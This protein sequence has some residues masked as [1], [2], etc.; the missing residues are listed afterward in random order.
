MYAELPAETAADLAAVAAFL[1]MAEELGISALLDRGVPFT[2]DEA[3]RA[4]TVPESAMVSFLAAMEASGLITRVA[5]DMTFV[6]CADFAE[7]RHESGY[8]AWALNANRPYLENAPEFLRDY[9]SSASKYSRDARWVAVSSQW[10]GTQGFYPQV[11]AEISRGHPGR[12]VD[13]GAGAGRLL[14]DILQ[15][16]TC[17]TGVAIDLSSAACAEARQAA[18]RADVADR[19][20]VMN[21]SIQSLVD[22]PAVLAGADVIHACFVMHDVIGDAHV[23]DAVLST[24]RASLA[25]G[26]KLVIVDAVPYSAEGRERA[27]SAL[28]TYLHQHSMGVDLPAQDSWEVAFR[29]AGFTEIA[30]TPLRMPAARMFVASG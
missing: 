13:L 11:V 9:E 17:A 27:F 6:T 28:F 15:H 24:C 19:L 10:V 5:N 16:L 30:C 23:F 1:E 7:R 3:A 22:D 2:A 4:T 8:L 29:R 25:E 20:Q 14:V 12:V 26:G 18:Y 21:R